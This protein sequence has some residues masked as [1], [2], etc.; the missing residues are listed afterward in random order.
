MLQRRRLNDISSVDCAE[1]HQTSCTGRRGARP[2]GRLPGRHG[3]D[4]TATRRAAPAFEAFYGATN[5][6]AAQ[7][8]LG[9]KAIA[10]T[11]EQWNDGVTDTFC[12]VQD[13]DGNALQGSMAG[14]GRRLS[15]FALVQPKKT[16]ATS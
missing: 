15:T 13:I 8:G 2:A 5:D 11:E 7:N 14:Q 1:Q 10:P 3:A 6:V 12:L 9:I 16:S 4:P